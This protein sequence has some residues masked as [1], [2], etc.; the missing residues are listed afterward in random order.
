M[1]AMA[2]EKVVAVGLDHLVLR[3]V[4]LAQARVAEAVEGVRVGVVV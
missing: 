1:E 2:K 3:R 4:A